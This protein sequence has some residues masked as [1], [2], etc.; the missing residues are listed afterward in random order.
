MYEAFLASRK[1][2]LSLAGKAHA[3]FEPQLHH[4]TKGEVS[5]HVH[6]LILGAV[7]APASL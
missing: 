7:I 3:N 4:K 2:E 6:D 5:G 1:G